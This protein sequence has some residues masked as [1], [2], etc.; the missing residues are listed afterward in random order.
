MIVRVNVVQ[1]VGLLLTETDVS[2]AYA[3]VIFRVLTIPI[4]EINNP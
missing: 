4:D 3:T 1:S 2:T